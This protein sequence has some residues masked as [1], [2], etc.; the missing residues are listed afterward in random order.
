MPADPGMMMMRGN[1]GGLGGTSGQ[2]QNNGREADQERIIE[3][4]FFVLVYI[5][6]TNGVH[7]GLQ[8]GA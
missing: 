6:L 3:N 2:D 8:G 7:K 1:P 5:A 4:N